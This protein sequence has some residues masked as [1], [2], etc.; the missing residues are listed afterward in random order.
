MNFLGLGTVAGRFRFFAVLEA[1]SWLGLLVGMAFK[2]LPAEG[3][4]IGVKIFGPVHGGI[5]ILFVLTALLASRELEWNWKTTV[6]ALLSSIPPFFTVVF[7]VW[8]VRTGKLGE[9][10]AAGTT[11]SPQTLAASS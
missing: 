6:L 8:A 1:L 9:L 2:Y 4:E 10:S 5:F 11:E 7:E 3:N